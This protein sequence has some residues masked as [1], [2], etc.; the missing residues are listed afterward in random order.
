[1]DNALGKSF[2]NY[3]F[4]DIREITNLKDMLAGSAELFGDYP[5]FWV[6]KEKGAPYTAVS[7]RLLQHDVE[8]LGTQL[9]RMGMKGGRVAV[10]GMSCYEWIVSYLAVINGT[11]VVVPIDKELSGPEIANL[12]RAGEVSTIFCTAAEC[13][14]ILEDRSISQMASFD[15]TYLLQ[16][17]LE[18]DTWN[19]HLLGIPVTEAD[20]G[21][22]I[23]AILDNYISIGKVVNSALI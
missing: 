3:W 14:G 5:A 15:D 12:M 7:Y 2:K 8:A 18:E 1:M 22:D 16:D 10:M 17:H 21:S 9:V 13:K 19:V 23:Q 6:K 20:A 4:S 11:G